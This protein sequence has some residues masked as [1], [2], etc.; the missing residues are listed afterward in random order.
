VE[1]VP[2][3]ASLVASPPENIKSYFSKFQKN[4]KGCDS[5]TAK[6]FSILQPILKSD[7][8]NKRYGKTLT[9]C[10]KQG[11]RMKYLIL[12]CQNNFRRRH[13]LPMHRKVV[14]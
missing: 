6:E 11:I 13:G 2:G 9:E 4:K 8:L 12:L 14:K 1:N 3:W 7:N 5:L 10:E